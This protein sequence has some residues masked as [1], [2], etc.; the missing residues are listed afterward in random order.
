VAGAAERAAG[1][2]ARGIVLYAGWWLDCTV[3]T[4]VAA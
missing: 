4:A 3:C 2:D 1:A